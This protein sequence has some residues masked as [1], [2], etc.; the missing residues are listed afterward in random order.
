M[1]GDG[2]EYLAP[3]RIV[4]HNIF[5]IHVWQIL[6]VAVFEKFSMS[7]RKFSLEVRSKKMF[8]KSICDERTGNSKKNPIEFLVYFQKK[9][10]VVLRYRLP[11]F[12]LLDLSRIISK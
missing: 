6:S 9:F 5:T 12:F 3:G 4:P 8:S 2:P 10:C 1:L 7:A 11:K